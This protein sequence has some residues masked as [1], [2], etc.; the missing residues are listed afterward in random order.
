MGAASFLPPTLY[1]QAVWLQDLL[2]LSNSSAPPA[3]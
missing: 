3:D 2:E 1:H